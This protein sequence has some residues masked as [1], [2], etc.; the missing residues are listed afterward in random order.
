MRSFSLRDA[1]GAVVWAIENDQGLEIAW[2]DYGKVP[3]GFRQKVPAAGRPP[4][5]L[6]PGE[7]LNAVTVTA[8]RVFTHRGFAVGAAAWSISDHE[9]ALIGRPPAE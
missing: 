6:V 3:A 7:T 2:L 1:G 8:T 5:R 9:M 4:R